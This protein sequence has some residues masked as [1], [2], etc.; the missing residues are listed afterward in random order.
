MVLSVKCLV[1]TSHVRVFFISGERWTQL[2]E[3]TL[4]I[5][6]MERLL[7]CSLSTGVLGKLVV[8]GFDIGKAW[9]G[10]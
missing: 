6:G 1:T 7:V 3:T 9:P 8:T 4:N 2:E 10:M 5:F